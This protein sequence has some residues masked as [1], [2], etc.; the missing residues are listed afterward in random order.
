MSPDF[1]VAVLFL[2]Q[3]LAVMFSQFKLISLQ[4]ILM[5]LNMCSSSVKDVDVQATI[6]TRAIALNGNTLYL[7]DDTRM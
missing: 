3:T 4:C 6:S 1:S 7:Y 5:V 2:F